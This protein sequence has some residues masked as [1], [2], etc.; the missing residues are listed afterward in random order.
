MPKIPPT[1]TLT[2]SSNETDINGLPLVDA[3]STAGTIGDLNSISSP[4]QKPT[5]FWLEE[6]T[7]G[8]LVTKD[9]DGTLRYGWSWD[10][11]NVGTIQIDQED[12]DNGDI[13]YPRFSTK[14]GNLLAFGDYQWSFC[15][16][17]MEKMKRNDPNLNGLVELGLP[18]QSGGCPHIKGLNMVLTV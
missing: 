15:P 16:T 10:K 14:P 5:I 11:V 6:G 17:N 9:E 13:F 3:R 8:R 4:D 7:S 2:I 1:F 12:A 18:S